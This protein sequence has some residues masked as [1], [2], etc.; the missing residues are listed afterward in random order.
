MSNA[1]VNEILI[2]AGA[3]F[4]CTKIDV[5][6]ED[7]EKSSKPG[8]EIRLETDNKIYENK[9]KMLRQTK[10]GMVNRISK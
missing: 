9:Q 5:S 2:H 3:K 6:Q 1:E 10:K 8:W 4:F 7:M